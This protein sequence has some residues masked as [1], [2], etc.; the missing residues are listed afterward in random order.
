[1]GGLHLTAAACS[2]TAAY[3]FFRFSLNKYSSSGT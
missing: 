3:V 2:M 1:M